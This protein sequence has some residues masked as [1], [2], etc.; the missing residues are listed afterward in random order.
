MGLAGGRQLPSRGVLLRTWSPAGQPMISFP[1]PDCGKNL[2][3]KDG[4]AGKRGKCP[5]C[6]KALQVPAAT[7]APP[8]P[9]QTWLASGVEGARTLPPLQAAPAPAAG[10][11]SSADVSR[12]QE[13]GKLHEQGILTDEEF[14]QQKALILGTR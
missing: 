6:G 8:A 3:V 14:A 9:F 7:V 2:Q 13:L 11:V 12:L 1:C 10:G 5:Q 4:L